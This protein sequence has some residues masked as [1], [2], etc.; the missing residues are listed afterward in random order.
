MCS[1]EIFLVFL[2]FSRE[3]LR[4]KISFISLKEYKTK[5]GESEKLKKGEEKSTLKPQEI[6]HPTE[7]KEYQKS[8]AFPR[9]IKTL[10]FEL[11]C[12]E[13]KMKSKSLQREALDISKKQKNLKF[14]TVKMSTIKKINHRLS[15][16]KTFFLS[17]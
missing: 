12:C 1:Y 9:A 6:F 15:R 3:F 13:E 2:S 14:S 10:A 4:L 8:Q 7:K 16:V 17:G 11:K 5:I